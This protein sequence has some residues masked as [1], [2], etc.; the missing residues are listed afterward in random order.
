[1][2][3]N[4]NF[5]YKEAIKLES[6]EQLPG[7][8]LNYSTFGKLN[9]KRDNII[10]V[11]HALTANANFLE[12]WPGL[13]GENTLYNPD[14]YFII[15]ANMIGSCYGSTGPLTENSLTGVPY[16]HSFPHL[17]NRDM[18]NTFDLLRKHLGFEKIHTL[19]GGSMGG[20]QALEWA[21]QEND[22]FENLII[23]ASNAKHSPWGV[24][25]NESQRQA[26]A[27]DLTWK[28]NTEKAGMKGMKVARSIALLSYRHYATYLAT[29][30]EENEN[31]IDDFKASSYQKYQGEK[32]AKRFNAFSYWTLSKAMDSHNIG[33]GRGGIEAALSSIK[34]RAL[35]IS[36]ATDQLFPVSEQKY[37]AD[38]V[39][40]SQFEII[41]STYGHDGF[42]IEVDQLTESIQNFYRESKL[43][44][45]LV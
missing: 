29:Q 28:L 20:Q 18:V 4:N 10:W 34:S 19:I 30:N 26:I 2:L 13:F 15:C 8:S 14:E 6:G 33:R 41:D 24:A 22:V 25:F 32:L 40:N 23:I 3:T 42:L 17:T 11:C 27:L 9:E 37:L 1:M 16:F 44:P 43:N 7:F 36:I 38:N 5:E 35:F 31:K 21:I 12:W 45:A 39:V